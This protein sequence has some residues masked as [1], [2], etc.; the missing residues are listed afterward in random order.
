MQ[1]AEP[2]VPLKRLKRIGKLLYIFMFAAT[3]VIAAL[4][5]AYGE[6]GDLIVTIPIAVMLALALFTERQQVHIPP[7][8]IILTIIVFYIS[9]GA[10]IL[11][12]D[13]SINLVSSYLIGVVTG[14]LGLIIIYMLLRTKPG[15][16]NESTSLV[17]L[18]VMST[19]LSIFYLIKIVQ[20]YCM[21]AISSADVISLDALMMESV[22]AILG[23]GTVG[24]LYYEDNK[25]RLF[26]YTLGSFL[27]ENAEI[28]GIEGSERE[29]IMRIISGGE[30][31]NLEFK[32]TMRTNLA[33]GEIDK[34]MEKAVLKTIVAFLNSNG[35]TLLI[36]VDDSGDICGVDLQNFESKDKMNLHFTNLVASQIGNEFL[37]YIKTTMVDFDDKTVIWVRCDPCPWP[38]FLKEGKTETFFVRTEASSVELTGM[39]L[40]K[41]VNNRTK[42]GS[43]KKMG[44]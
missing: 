1:V 25:H 42:K 24:L 5:V 28:L 9:L 11:Y 40:I 13:K 19:S 30:S 10:G 15:M 2:T 3:I 33:T 31:K 39:A 7:I 12:D 22:M 14:L 6:I 36:G 4:D 44:A 21:S 17:S 34:R 37:P 16:R 26:K 23:G 32:S 41:Y 35:G 20:Y 18:M 38:V 43:R 29:S 27:E 8:L